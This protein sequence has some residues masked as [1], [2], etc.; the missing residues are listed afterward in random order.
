MANEMLKAGDVVRLKTGGPLMT[1]SE[2]GCHERA[3]DNDVLCKWFFKVISRSDQGMAP[4]GY[5]A[6]VREWDGPY[7][8]YFGHDA[9][10]IATP[11]R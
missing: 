11:D 2:V 4:V 6:H 10:E 7:Q 3:R 1:V 8:E 9:L 5:V